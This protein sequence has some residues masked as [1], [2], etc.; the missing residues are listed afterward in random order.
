MH[1][2]KEGRKRKETGKKG[3]M[4]IM[5]I[6]SDNRCEVI[7]AYPEK[8]YEMLLLYSLSET[9][10]SWKIRKMLLLRNTCFLSQEL[11]FTY[12]NGP[13]FLHQGHPEF[14]QLKVATA[15]SMGDALSV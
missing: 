12:L 11:C 4:E 5:K 8:D 3:G 6:C 13:R 9:H 2:V 7:A 14:H 15:C 1:I 10:L